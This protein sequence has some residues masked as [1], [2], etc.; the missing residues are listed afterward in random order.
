ML[1]GRFKM[2][3]RGRLFIVLPRRI[4]Q[5][6]ARFQFLSVFMISIVFIFNFLA[7]CPANSET[8][9]PKAKTEN[10]VAAAGQNLPG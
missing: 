1:D 4:D 2:N 8:K 6:K 9:A 10:P 5:M 7:A 3:N